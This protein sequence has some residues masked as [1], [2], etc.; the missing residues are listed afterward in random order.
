MSPPDFIEVYE[1]ALSA[2]VCAQ[3]LGHFERSGQAVPGRV[4][5]GVLPELKDSRDIGISGKPEWREAEAA[6]N[7]AMFTGLLA[8]LRK[9]RHVL[10]APLM[11]QTRDAQTGGLRRLSEADFDTLSD[12]QLSDI[13]R[14]LLRPGTINLQRYTADQGGYP[15]WHCELYPKDASA[16]TLHRTLL[17]TI[18]LNDG[19]AEGETEFLYQQR[20]I[21]PKTGSL[22]I[23][24]TAFTHT[25]RGNRPRGGDKYIATSWVLFQRA[26]MLF[27]DK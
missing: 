20:K 1:N 26:E 13:V 4:G 18:Y 5:A 11:V 16:D 15:Y 23:A 27:P 6:L 2:D 3:L 24:P 22:L 25:H 12:A 7:V 21:V 19:F 8:Y 10:L 9:Y 14:S 17:W